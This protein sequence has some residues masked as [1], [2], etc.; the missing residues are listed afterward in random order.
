MAHKLANNKDIKCLVFISV[1]NIF[2]KLGINSLVDII[3]NKKLILKVIGETK[4]IEKKTVN[5]L[6]EFLKII[7]DGFANVTK[8]ELSS[9][10]ERKNVRKKN[11]N[12]F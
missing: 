9:F 11:T 12:V 6:K 4:G 2:T 8:E 7:F 5:M 3:N 1:F 10:F